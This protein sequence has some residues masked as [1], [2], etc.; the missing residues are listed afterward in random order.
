MSNIRAFVTIA[1]ATFKECIFKEF[2]IGN[3]ESAWMC[4][5]HDCVRSQLLL[6][7]VYAPHH[8]YHNNFT[9]YLSIDE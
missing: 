2:S 7:C 8:T 4:D 3:I 6:V 1:I 5:L 9:S